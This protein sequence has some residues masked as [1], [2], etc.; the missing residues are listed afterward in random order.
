MSDSED[1]FSDSDNES[2]KDPITDT[3]KSD[4]Y[5]SSDYEMDE[6]TR[7]IIF[8]HAKLS[9]TSSSVFL[10]S[11]VIP[12][13]K[14]SKKRNKKPDSNKAKSLQQFMEEMEKKK[15]EGKPKKWSS[16]RLNE[17]KNKLGINKEKVVRRKFNPRLPPPTHLTFKKKDVNVE[18]VLD[19]HSFP[20]LGGADTSSNN[21]TV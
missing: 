5:E 7:R 10:Q 19:Q 2:V 8:N 11:D 14:S 18:V 21:V 17:K 6:E 13:K 16:K 12:K 9:D 1:Y 20:T 4:G 3:P 15:E